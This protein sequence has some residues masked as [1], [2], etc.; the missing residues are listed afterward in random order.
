MFF[1][2]LT[3]KLYVLILIV[4]FLYGV[5]IYSREAGLE[6]IHCYS[7]TQAYKVQIHV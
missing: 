4:S 1:M 2:G 3:F 7:N 6:G 5:L